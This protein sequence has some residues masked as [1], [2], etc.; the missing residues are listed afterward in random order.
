MGKQRKYLDRG[1]KIELEGR[2]FKVDWS[3]LLGAGRSAV[4]KGRADEAAFLSE[5]MWEGVNPAV[6][7]P[8]QRRLTTR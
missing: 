7:T 2:P 8:A 3:T 4:Q 1:R 5:F 6:V